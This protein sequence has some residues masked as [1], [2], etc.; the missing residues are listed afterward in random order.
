VAIITIHSV[1]KTNIKY[2]PNKNKKYPVY[3]RKKYPI[4]TRKKYPVSVYNI[5]GDVNIENTSAMAKEELSRD[6]ILII[7]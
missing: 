6:H 5:A 4:Y 2:K 1:N 3:T 7:P